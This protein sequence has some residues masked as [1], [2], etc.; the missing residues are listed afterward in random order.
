M[1]S[2]KLTQI[3]QYN[4]LPEEQKKWLI[5]LADT[6]PL[7]FQQLK[8]L[9][10]YCID[11]ICWQAGSPERFYNP[12]K[13]GQ[14][15]G[16]RAAAMV[17]HQ[18]Q[19]QYKELKINPKKYASLSSTK[20]NEKT[21]PSA[22]MLSID[23]KGSIMGTCPVASEK[24]RCC[25]LHTL[26]VVQQCG[27]GCSY[28]SIQSFYHGDQVRFIKELPK[29][30]AK[31]KLKPQE[32]YHIGTGQSSD[33]LMW[34]NEFG[35]LDSLTD[36]AAS[37]PN[38]GLE[39]KSKSGKIDYF[40]DKAPPPNIIF[41]WSLNPSIVIQNEETGTASLKQRLESARK[42]ADLGCPVG[43]HFHPIV[44]YKGWKKDYKELVSMVTDMFTPDEV[45]M[46]SLGT[47]TFI[48]SVIK[49]IRNR[50]LKSSILQ[51]PMEEIGGKMSYPFDIKIQLFSNLYRS[52]PNDWIENVFFYMCMEDIRLWEP[53][54]GRSYTT[55]EK[56]EQDMLDAYFKKVNKIHQTHVSL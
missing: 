46:I 21:F 19:E 29:Q 33:S 43:F 10:E 26:D 22:Q 42:M 47:L 25:N 38:V 2:D 32:R 40:L 1:N 30:L 6:W 4:V 28:C 9:T 31:L 51:M 54:L 14:V 16:K 15:S 34:G 20:I 11:M 27:F 49:R 55:N 24:T 45:V 35:I 8:L 44:W 50:L 39:M 13:L 12:E 17:F 36:F 53:V 7:S 48:K 41:T 3:S 5:S 37:H 56:F 52:F 18:I 23:S